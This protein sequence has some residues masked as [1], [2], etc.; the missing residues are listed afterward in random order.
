MELQ[1]I[2]GQL[3]I[4]NG[5][6]QGTTPAP[7]ILACPAPSKAAR[8]RGRDFL[9][10]HLTLS[11]PLEDTAVLVQ[12]LLEAVSRR[13]YQSAGSVTAALRK[14]IL[15]A[16]LLLLRL[17][18][19]QTGPAREGAISVAAL[20]GNELFMAQA[21][22]SLA[23]IG[24]NFG[25]ER[26]PP[27]P[28][29]KA[30][31]GRTASLDLRYFHNRLQ[32]GNMLLLA[33]PRLAYLSAQAMEPALVASD[34]ETGLEELTRLVDAGTARLL[35]VEFADET[36]DLL[37]D[38]V[39]A[40]G[41]PG[42]AGRPLSPPTGQPQR[43]TTQPAP[44]ALTPRRPQ[45]PAIDAQA[46]EVTA[47]RATSKTALGLSRLT[48]GLADVM[49]QLQPADPPEE[50][51]IGWALPALLAIV[52]PILII[53]IVT[54][55]Y[56]QQGRVAR[57]AEIRQEMNQLLLAGQDETHPDAA[58]S[59]YQAVIALAHE[60]ES[61]RAGDSEIGRLRRQAQQELDRL[62]GVTRLTARSI[63]QYSDETRATSV[64]LQLDGEGGIYALDSA[65]NRLFRHP[66]DNAFLNLDRDQSQTLLRAGDAHGSHIVRQLVDILWRPQ[67]RAVTRDGLLTLDQSG[68][69]IV[70]NP[71]FAAGIRA[72]PLGFATDWRQPTA[73]AS[74]AE[75]LY[76]LDR[77]AQQVWKYY[78]DGEGFILREDDPILVFEDEA[79][80]DRAVDLAI[81]S[82]DGS[83]L[84]LY[85]DGRLRRFVRGRIMWTED[86]LRNGGLQQPLV[87]PTA[88]KIIG[89]GLNSSIYVADPGSDRVIQFSLGGTFL[90]QY[91][92][93]SEDGQEE[94]FGQIVNFDVAPDAP[95]RLFFVT[96]E[97][98]LY[99]ATQ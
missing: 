74:F 50:E 56:F 33:D 73:I 69:A 4:V 95:L 8:G 66:T 99:I 47:R 85:E 76:I 29:A 63:Y 89:R 40:G 11:G 49:E 18:L 36:A 92:A 53:L 82:E 28:P 38:L 88:L 80:L 87:A 24:H 10:V 84:V 44:A 13:F 86:D 68:A 20:R 2:T 32:P 79:N 62:D 35:L 65:N 78:P 19:S 42:T 58:R 5:E 7:G 91:K 1:A 94:M 75:R 57:F 45:L 90:A 43:T 15:E 23:L 21:G 30:P 17:N 71:G 26:L 39:G 6:S 41:R 14:A 25:V 31:M 37:P 96:G 54:G 3:Y 60:A 22:E 98:Q 64:A 46:V 52:I 70:Y 48:G 67:G 59:H 12:D 77:G 16:N 93:I 97:N 34:I 51:E 55:A 27:T 81:F 72:V 83:V 61:M 9:F